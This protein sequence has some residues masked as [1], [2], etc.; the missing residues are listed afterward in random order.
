MRKSV[1]MDQNHYFLSAVRPESMEENTPS[2]IMSG[3][4]KSGIY[5]LNSEGI[6][7]RLSS[8]STTAVNLN[9]V[10]ESFPTHLEKKR[11]DFVNPCCSRKKKLSVPAGGIVN[12][13]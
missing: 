7:K 6:L 3:F 4:C 12:R 1:V 13:C 8:K 2:N 11:S 9:L 5:P 10:G